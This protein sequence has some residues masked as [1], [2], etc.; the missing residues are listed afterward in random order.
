[1][2]TQA[3]N[4][5][6]WEQS[7]YPREWVEQRH[8]LWAHSDWEVLLSTLKEGE[9]WPMEPEAIGILLEK[10]R[11]APSVKDSAC[12]ECGAPDSTE[13]AARG[14]VVT[15]FRTLATFA[16]H[17]CKAQHKVDLTFIDKTEGVDVRCS[18]GGIDHIPPLVWCQPCGQGLSTGWQSKVISKR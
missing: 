2:N 5:L 14:V 4:L 15:R 12:P 9:F 3:Q 17:R 13:L 1:M 10:L 11:T 16:C 8:G 7:G 6:R 18:C